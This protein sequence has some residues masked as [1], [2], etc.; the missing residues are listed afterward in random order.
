MPDKEKYSHRFFE[1]GLKIAYFRRLNK[2]S[3]DDL[4]ERVG[5]S[6]KYL[7]QLET[8]STVKP[9]SLKTLFAIADA[10]NVQPRKFFE[11]TDE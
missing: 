2:L 5:I 1:I 6:S 10:L 3:Q 8:Q 9:V 4:A 11:F 7:S